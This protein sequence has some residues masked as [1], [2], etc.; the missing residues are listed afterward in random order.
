VS[1]PCPPASS[2]LHT[3]IVGGGLKAARPGRLQHRSL[4]IIGLIVFAILL[5][6][7]VTMVL[8]QPATWGELVF[9]PQW[10]ACL[11]C[12]PL[13]AIAPFASLIWALRKDASHLR[14]TGAIAGMVAGAVGAAA[15]TFHHPADSIRFL[16]LWYGGPIIAC[17]LV[18]ALLGPRLLRW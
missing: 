16:V 3:E 8:S 4:A 18:G 11:V 13:F 14:W 10:A 12:I 7:I 1:H 15:Y 17:A 2:S 6:G 9:G 5:A